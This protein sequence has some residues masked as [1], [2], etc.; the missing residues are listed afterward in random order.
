[1]SDD[2]CYDPSLLDGSGDERAQRL[3]VAGF[4][5]LWRG[6]QPLVADLAEDPAVVTAM[7][8]AG[9][10]EVGDDGRLVAIHGLAARPTRHRVFHRD[11]QIHTWC[12]FD[13]VGI[14]AALGIDASAETSCPTC[15]R[16]ITVSLR[17]GEVTDLSEVRLWLPSADCSHLVEDFCEH[18][19]LYCDSDHLTASIPAGTSGE[20]LTLAQAADLGRRTWSDVAPDPTT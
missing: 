8:A 13:A 14:P 9:R 1:V 4:H 19:N 5:A 7:V 6:D 15:G 11:G 20:V 3:G 2:R 12:A 10:L 18:A 16:T 17:A